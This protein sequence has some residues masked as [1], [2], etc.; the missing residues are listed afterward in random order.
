MAKEKQN[1]PYKSYADEGFWDGRRGRKNATTMVVTALAGVGVMALAYFNPQGRAD[2]KEYSDYLKNHFSKEIVRA[3]AEKG[4]RHYYMPGNLTAAGEQYALYKKQ[5]AQ[6]QEK[7]V[8]GD[9]TAEMA[10]QDVKNALTLADVRRVFRQ[11]VDGKG[12]GSVVLSAI[13]CHPLAH[14]A[15]DTTQAFDCNL[16]RAEV[17]GF[18]D[19]KDGISACSHIRDSFRVVMNTKTNAIESLHSKGRGF[20]SSIDFDGDK[21]KKDIGDLLFR[22][23][24]AYAM[25]DMIYFTKLD[26]PK[27]RDAFLAF[28]A[29]LQKGP[30]Q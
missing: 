29:C 14:T 11:G 28:S 20:M 8:A 18:N 22:N 3:T 19:K 6:L 4:A 16:T 30:Q 24:A 2:D 7:Y 15:T 27:E 26:K 12:D 25:G 1:K 13:S 17:G 10:A 23:F 21:A 9:H 5:Q